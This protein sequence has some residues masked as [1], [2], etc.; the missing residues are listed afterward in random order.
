MYVDKYNLVNP[1]EAV[2]F[3]TSHQNYQ[4][5]LDYL[6]TYEDEFEGDSLHRAEVI[7]NLFHMGVVGS[8]DR[9]VCCYYEDYVIKMPIESDTIESNK[10]EVDLF[11]SLKDNKELLDLLCPILYHDDKFI[12]TPF[13]EEFYMEDDDEFFAMCEDVISKFKSAGIKFIDLY[14]QHQFGILDGKIVILDYEDY[15]FII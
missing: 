13:C 14:A 8:G 6:E 9:R 12:V 15:E 5:Y 7:S 3:I 2:S 10:K 1:S 4:K 11:N